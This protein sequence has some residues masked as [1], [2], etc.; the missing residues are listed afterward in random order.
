[1]VKF[2]QIFFDR[3]FGMT[4]KKTNVTSAVFF[5]L[6]LLC[7]VGLVVYCI[8]TAN[9][10]GGKL[11]IDMTEPSTI[12]SIIYLAA[13]LMIMIF[14]FSQSYPAVIF[15]SLIAG[16]IMLFNGIKGFIDFNLVKSYLSYE[17]I[18]GLGDVKFFYISI[19]L[20]PTL[21]GLAYILMGISIAVN[22][23]KQSAT[24]LTV[25]TVITSI[26]SILPISYYF[27]RIIIELVKSVNPEP[28]SREMVTFLV[29][30]F[31]CMILIFIFSALGI[32]FGASC[33][34]FKART[35][36]NY[37]PYS[38]LDL[39]NPYAAPGATTSSSY[40]DSGNNTFSA[41][42][43]HT[44]Y[45][46]FTG[47]DNNT[48]ES[49]QTYGSSTAADNVSGMKAK[50][51]YA[52]SNAVVN[53]AN[54]T[55]TE[56]TYVEHEF[57]TPD[58][59]KQTEELHNSSENVPPVSKIIVDDGARFDEQQTS[60]FSV[61]DEIQKFRTLADNGI[62]SEVEFEEKKRQLLNK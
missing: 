30:I 16:G 33:F 56:D 59:P 58:T 12:R 43:G 3:R 32:M 28:Y 17:N 8:M 13:V 27:I 20:Y 51:S 60:E 15:F 34:K 57:G 44:F 42:G 45:Q 53:E 10:N 2:N 29:I 38:E 23:Q 52:N 25:V 5:L 41:G 26:I 9:S 36:N 21:A 61:A 39:S 49:Y 55:A 19:L 1:M 47:N 11:N 48:D 6:M 31:I 24:G 35:R 14:M 40:S 46:P 62:I 18:P 7:N 37:T 4:N 50:E 22:T 54:F